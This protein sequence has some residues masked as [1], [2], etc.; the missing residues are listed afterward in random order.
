[1]IKVII[2]LTPKILSFRVRQESLDPPYYYTGDELTIKIDV[3][4]EGKRTEVTHNSE[5]GFL[6]TNLS[7]KIIVYN[8]KF[9]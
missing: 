6:Y 7:D 3:L 1:M 4:T 5:D 8:L 2:L 9:Y